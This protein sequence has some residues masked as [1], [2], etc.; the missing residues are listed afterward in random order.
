MTQK[1]G[2]PGHN[3]VNF[4]ITFGVDERRQPNKAE[5]IVKQLRLQDHRRL[6]SY[7]YGEQKF[8]F[9]KGW[10]RRR[11]WK[12]KELQLWGNWQVNKK[13][14]ANCNWKKKSTLEFIIYT[15]SMKLTS[16]QRLSYGVQM[17]VVGHIFERKVDSRKQSY[18]S[19]LVIVV[20][21]F[22]NHYIKD[23]FSTITSHWWSV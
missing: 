7:S 14:M 17:I 19:F 22:S 1:T 21:V 4:V 11:L 16:E 3:F 2:S 10:Y 13:S 8:E 15:F 6:P 12:V 23:Q 18:I 20:I 9:T 5:N